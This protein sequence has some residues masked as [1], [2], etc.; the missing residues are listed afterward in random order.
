MGGVQNHQGTYIQ[1]E[2]GTRPEGTGSPPEPWLL[3]EV[4]DSEHNV[5]SDSLICRLE[6][7]CAAVRTVMTVSGRVPESTEQGQCRQ[8]NAGGG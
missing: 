7:P 4:S 3:E 6:D 8:E 5:V 2:E 1:R